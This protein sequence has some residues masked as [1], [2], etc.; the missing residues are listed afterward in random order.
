MD[1]IRAET[2][3]MRVILALCH[4]IKLASAEAGNEVMSMI[5]LVIA[6][7]A[8]AMLVGGVAILLHALKTWREERNQGHGH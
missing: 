8:L 6:V 5:A 7:T 4:G 2:P 3:F 1:S